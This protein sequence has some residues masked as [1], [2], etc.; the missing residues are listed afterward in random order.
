MKEH[1]PYRKSAKRRKI[2]I[3]NH[4]RFYRSLKD[5][6]C[7]D[8][9]MSYPYYVMDFDHRN[10]KAKKFNPT[11]LSKRTKRTILKETK[12]C[13]LVCSNCHRIRSYKRGSGQQ[14]NQP[15]PLPL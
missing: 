8:C 2:R 4:K 7:M 5:K 15:L 9:G 12:K 1:I 14:L 6:P 11:E 3:E 13:D 10:G